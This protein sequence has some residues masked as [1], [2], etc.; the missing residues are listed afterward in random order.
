MRLTSIWIWHFDFYGNQAT[1][2]NIALQK[3]STEGM[4]LGYQKSLSTI[5]TMSPVAD[6]VTLLDPSASLSDK[7]IAA[8]GIFSKPIMYT[9]KKINQF[10]KFVDK[11]GDILGSRTLNGLSLKINKTGDFT[12]SFGKWSGRIDLYADSNQ[13]LEE[14]IG[15]TRDKQFH[16]AKEGVKALGK[17]MIDSLTS[18]AESFSEPYMKQS[19]AHG[20]D[21]LID[22]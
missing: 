19:K 8:G 3:A 12:H 13:V 1:S 10:S 18:F 4:I 17:A 7:A 21:T 11:G 5:Y 16:Y 9:G 2:Q 15:F 14:E 6:G 20:M 22:E